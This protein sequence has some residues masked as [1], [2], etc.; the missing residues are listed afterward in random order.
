MSARSAKAGLRRSWVSLPLTPSPF[1][2]EAG[3]RVKPLT[4][5]STTGKYTLLG[6]YSANKS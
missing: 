3:M 4:Y 5:P 1:Q 2:G 6:K